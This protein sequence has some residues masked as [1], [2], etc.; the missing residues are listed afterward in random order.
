MVNKGDIITP[1]YT[2]IIPD[3]G[4]T[5]MFIKGQQYVILNKVFNKRG[6]FYSING[7]GK[8]YKDWGKMNYGFFE[9][10]LLE[11]FNIHMTMTKKGWEKV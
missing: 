8:G 10:E 3:T 4:C 9:N 1:K 2:F 7:D 11:K 6:T 5:F